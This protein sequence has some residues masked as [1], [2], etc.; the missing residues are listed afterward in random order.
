MGWGTPTAVLTAYIT[1]L[2][3]VD[4]SAVGLMFI[5]GVLGFLTTLA[6][7]IIHRRRGWMM[8]LLIVGLIPAGMSSYYLV[9]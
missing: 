4:S 2:A 5:S 8:A 3:R 6:G 7:L 9:S 1:H